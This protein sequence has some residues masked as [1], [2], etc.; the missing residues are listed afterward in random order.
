[1]TQFNF[2]WP[3]DRTLLGGTTLG[4]SGSGSYGNEGVLGIPQNSS[5]GLFGVIFRTLVWGSLT[6]LQRCSLCILQPKLTVPCISKW[7]KI[8]YSDKNIRM[9]LFGVKNSMVLLFPLLKGVCVIN[10]LLYM[11]GIKILVKNKQKIWTVGWLLACLVLWVLWHIILRRLFIAK[12]IFIEI[13]SYISNN[14]V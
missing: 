14:S 2:I 12:S 11:D 13:I 10:Q 1:M 9:H 6:L 7:N 8:E 5:I 4:Q 3:I